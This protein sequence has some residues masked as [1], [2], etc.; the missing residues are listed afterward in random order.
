MRSS[1][2]A[3]PSIRWQWRRRNCRME[4]PISDHPAMRCTL[5]DLVRAAH[6][7]LTKPWSSRR[8]FSSSLSPSIPTASDHSNRSRGHLFGCNQCP[9]WVSSGHCPASAPC[10]LYPRR[11]VMEP[12]HPPLRERHHFRYGVCHGNASAAQRRSED[13]A[14]VEVKG[15]P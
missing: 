9:L 11:C 6:L 8:G 3:K 14:F 12:R 13:Q 5:S 10:L 7:H 2:C 1:C 15:S 4:S